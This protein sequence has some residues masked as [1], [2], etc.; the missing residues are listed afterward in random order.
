[1]TLYRRAILGSMTG[2]AALLLL[3]YAASVVIVLNEFGQ[4]ESASVR[5][6]TRRLNQAVVDVLNQMSAMANDYAAWHDT[7]AFIEDGDTAYID[8]TL[9]REKMQN[10]ELDL[11]LFIDVSG[12]LVYGETYDSATS[13]VAP[14]S[15]ALL[16]DL[17]VHRALLRHTN[18]EGNVI[19]L[20][21]PAGWPMLVASRPILT[22]QNKGPIRGAVI[23][24]R[25][26]EP[27]EIERLMQTT[28]LSLTMLVP[29]S[30]D[31]AAE[32]TRVLPELPDTQSIYLQP[33]DDT[34]IQGFARVDDLAGRP[35]L[36]WRTTAPRPIFQQAQATLRYFL[37]A[38]VV[39]G[40]CVALATFYFLQRWIRIQQALEASE[41]RFRLLA[42]N[43]TDMIT[44]V[45]LSGQILYVSP[46]CQTLLGRAPEEMI[47]Q[48]IDVYFEG[49]NLPTY[50]RLAAPMPSE[51]ETNTCVHQVLHQDGRAI[52]FETTSRVV[53]DPR[54]GGLEIHASSRD[55]TARHQTEEALRQSEERYHDLFENANDLIQSV[56]PAGRYLY[57]N[58]AWRETLGYSEDEL[59]RLNMIDVI[60]P[61]CREACI[62]KFSRVKQGESIAKLETI[63]HTKDGRPIHVE[64]SV[65]AHLIANQMVATR[66]IFRDITARKQAEEALKESEARYRQV[67]EGNQ[68]VQLLIDP[69]TLAIV[70]GNAAAASFYGYGREI[71][72]TMSI[73]DIN[74]LPFDEIRSRM[75]AAASR[76][77]TTYHFLH[78]M[79]GGQLR[80]VEVYA[81]PV[82]VQSQQLMHVLVVDI[83]ERKQAEAAERAQRVRTEALLTAIRS[84]SS[85]LDVA[86]V[87]E[88]V[89]QQFVNALDFTSAYICSW[90]QAEGT[91]TL[92]AEWCGPAAT[93]SE[94]LSELGAVYHLVEDFGDDLDRWLLPGRT[95]ISQ[96]D[97]PNLH[98]G[99]RE[100]ILKYDGHTVLTVPLVLRDVSIGY[101]DLWESRCKREFTA[102]EIT[103]AQAI[104]QQAAIAMDHARL[105]AS[106]RR[107]AE[108][109]ELRVSQRTRE[110]T[111]ANQRLTELDR[112]KDEFVARVSHELRTPLANMKLYIGLL[113]QGKPEKRADYLNTL[114]IETARLMKLIE[115]LLDISQLEI[116]TLSL[117]LHPLDWRPLMDN[118]TSTCGAAERGLSIE[119]GPARVS[120][121]IQGDE[122]L[123]TRAVSNLLTNAINYTPPG[124]VITI[125]SALQQE[126]ATSWVTIT[127]SDT[128]PGISARDLPHIFTRFYRGETARNYK[129]PGTG[130]GLAICKEAVEKMGG[131]ITVES[132]L[133]KGAAFTIWLRVA[134][135][136]P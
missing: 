15:A 85:S 33:V 62:E 58:R 7:Y 116:D 123:L 4:I 9:G 26:L 41:Q 103:L 107:Y 132:E 38:F 36:I 100:H 99:M 106:V 29:G 86:Q 30:S 112:L 35:T 52:W 25:Y 131:R 128:G 110:L 24:G 77:G 119:Y 129:I 34:T 92:L 97:D 14:L 127:V 87:L 5:Q 73:A 48:K 16:R 115:D 37:L 104:A 68:V 83:T 45:T 28:G 125:T 75:R 78:R 67:F 113:D 114:R 27:D 8:S 121:Q 59:S 42:D 60:D 108:E 56:D 17:G 134:G 126:D 72:R 2:I 19:G 135:N 69:A 20:I 89:A 47:G 50:E 43:S 10:L 53:P 66:G 12:Q 93:P 55:V 18:T 64:G 79:A 136:I 57:A 88:L 94:Q 124:G 82:A 1:M 70:D 80:D 122:Q 111:E 13:Q 117:R 84:V 118:L 40:L 74:T 65:N 22:S 71:L 91:G 51:P 105:Y 96:V 95:L 90:N 54:T 6:D 23:M 11:L 76:T 44:R 133:G 46:A 109:L 63:F 102:E 39:I 32:F 120:A 61:A 130:L 31:Q 101:A 49:L 81:S 3:L 21:A 98:P